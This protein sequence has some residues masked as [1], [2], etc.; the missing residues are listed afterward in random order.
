MA[1]QGKG[2]AELRGDRGQGAA[3][4]TLEFGDVVAYSDWGK[5]D[6]GW[7]PVEGG[8][9]VLQRVLSAAQ[10]RDDGGVD[11]TVVLRFPAGFRTTAPVTHSFWEEVLLLRGELRDL[12]LQRTFRA[13][14]YCCRH[15]GTSTDAPTVTPRV[16]LCGPAGTLARHTALTL[17]L[18]SCSPSPCRNGARAVRNGCRAV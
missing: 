17:C 14:Q 8:G 1:S 9:G 2:A 10:P 18:L 16:E 11:R 5:D 4:P 12:T 13:G 15:P 7:E 3:K 6:R